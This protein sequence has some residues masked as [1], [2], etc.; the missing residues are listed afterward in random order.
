[1]RKLHED[2]MHEDL[3]DVLKAEYLKQDMIDVILSEV[4][5]YGYGCDITI[6]HGE[7]DSVERLFDVRRSEIT[8]Y[9]KKLSEYSEIHMFM[10]FGTYVIV[11][12]GCGVYPKKDDDEDDCR[13]RIWYHKIASGVY[14]KAYDYNDYGFRKEFILVDENHYKLRTQGL[15]STCTGCTFDTESPILD[16]RNKISLVDNSWVSYDAKIIGTCEISGNVYAGPGA[17]L[18]NT[19]LTGNSYV[20][21]STVKN[22]VISG[23]SRIRE[24]DVTASIIENCRLVESDDVICKILTDVEIENNKKRKR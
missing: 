22:S 20:E 6:K 13:D 1:M 9:V 18:I 16:L 24:T 8:I 7:E 12:D 11:V 10:S 5:Y 19:S 23:E 3:I 2:I 17:V 21:N 4:D 14:A 15:V